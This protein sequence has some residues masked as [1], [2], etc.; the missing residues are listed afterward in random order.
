M[1]G[2]LA[3]RPEPAA[4]VVPP[5]AEVQQ[6]YHPRPLDDP[7]V[8]EDTIAAEAAHEARPK[9]Y[10][11]V[12]AELT[13]SSPGALSPAQIQQYNDVG[14]TEPIQIYSQAEAAANREYFDEMMATL[15]AEGRGSYSINGFH[16]KCRAQWDMAMHPKI[17]DLVQDILGPNFVCVAKAGPRRPLC[18]FPH[19]LPANEQ[20]SAPC[21]PVA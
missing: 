3:L 7:R 11:F 9:L 16:M 1:A 17:L 19:T 18:S 13:G 21:P 2:H 8:T 15:E 10:G 5:P 14:Y 12:P 20:C 4:A 6:L